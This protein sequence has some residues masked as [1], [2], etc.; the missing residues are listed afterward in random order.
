[1]TVGEQGT[2]GYRG[3]GAGKIGVSVRFNGKID[4]PRKQV[5]GPGPRKKTGSGPRP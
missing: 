1:M 3:G 5:V 4:R 2:H